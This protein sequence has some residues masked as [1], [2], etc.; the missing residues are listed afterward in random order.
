MAVTIIPARMLDHTELQSVLTYAA[1]TD[2]DFANTDSVWLLTLTGNVTFT[3]SNK[4]AGKSK[5][6]IITGGASTRTYTFPAG[7]VFMDM[8][9]PTSLA[10]NK[11]AFLH[12]YCQGTA[13]ADVSAFYSVQP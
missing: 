6:I 8:V 3:T 13:E 5:T 2:I 9:A 7:W 12:L 4:A 1:T 11:K 10:A